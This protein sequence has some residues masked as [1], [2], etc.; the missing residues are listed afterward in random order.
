VRAFDLRRAR[1]IGQ[2]KTHLQQVLLTTALNVV[3]LV[4]WLAGTPR[5]R[6]HPSPFA[7]LLEAA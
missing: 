7:T 5:A 2:A 3:R 1:Y 6:T 4:S